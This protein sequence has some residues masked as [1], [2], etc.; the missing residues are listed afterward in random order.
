MEDFGKYNYSAYR[1][2]GVFVNCGY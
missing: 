1:V 2:M